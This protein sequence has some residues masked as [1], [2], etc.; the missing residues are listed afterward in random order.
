MQGYKPLVRKCPCCGHEAEFYLHVSPVAWVT[1]PLQ[2][3]AN[4]REIKA[5]LSKVDWFSGDDSEVT[6]RCKLCGKVVSDVW[7]NNVEELEKIEKE[8]SKK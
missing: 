5:D 4:G 3:N 2:L 8:K 6:V 7:P 1:A